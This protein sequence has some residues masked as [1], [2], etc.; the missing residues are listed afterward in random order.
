MC[1]H[2][3]LAIEDYCQ[4]RH[5][6]RRPYSTSHA[7]CGTTT[8]PSGQM[9]GP[10]SCDCTCPYEGTLYFNAPC[11]R[12]LSNSSLFQSLENKIRDVL[13]LTPG[14]V[15]LQYPSFTKDD[16]LQVHLKLFPSTGNYFN[17]SEIQKIGFDLSYQTFKAPLVF[18]LYYFI[19]E[20]YPFPG[21]YSF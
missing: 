3:L 17:R 5:R 9:H 10:Q 8:C 15:S 20:P 7:D 19:A 16:Y 18:G 1:N 2:N 4:N 6:S 11:F 12:D 14:S 21:A 13:G